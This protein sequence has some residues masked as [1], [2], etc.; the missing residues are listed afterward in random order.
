MGTLLIPGAND[1]DAELDAMTRWL[2]DNLG[3]DVPLHFSAFHPAYHY[4]EAQATPVAT[5]RRAHA[6][7]Q[8]N[9]LRY[10]YTGNVPDDAGRDTH[11]PHCDERLVTRRGYTVESYRLTPAGNCPTCAT[12]IPGF[13][14]APASPA[15]PR[16]SAA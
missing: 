4:R 13:W 8:Q 9:G 10:V 12:P 11:C 3:L 1:T 15:M 16:R 5:L 2:V 7:A 14:G 6:I